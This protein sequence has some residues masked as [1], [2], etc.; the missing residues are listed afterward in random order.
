[1]QHFVAI[2]ENMH[3]KFQ[4]AGWLS[5]LTHDLPS[6]FALS[7][8]PVHLAASRLTRFSLGG[9]HLSCERRLW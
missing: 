7:G 6:S 5:F 9:L 2:T 3:L 1:M 8:L 4:S